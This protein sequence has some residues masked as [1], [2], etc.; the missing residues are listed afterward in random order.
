MVV[1]THSPGRLGETPIDIPMRRS[2]VANLAIIVR[3]I[4]SSAPA[5][6]ILNHR[7]MAK[8]SEFAPHGELWTPAISRKCQRLLKAGAYCDLTLKSRELKGRKNHSALRSRKTSEA[9]KSL[10]LKSEWWSLSAGLDGLYTPSRILEVRA[11][12]LIVLQFEDDVR[13]PRDVLN[14]LE[15]LR[16]AHWI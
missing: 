9:S 16:L 10:R 8:E 11:A 5:M 6:V 4:R 14:R 12:P 3:Q 13:S 2:F 7:Q 15:F 1:W